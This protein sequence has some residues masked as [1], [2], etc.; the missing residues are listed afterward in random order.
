MK[1][2]A[3][4]PV[5]RFVIW[6]ARR[7]VAGHEPV[8]QAVSRRADLAAYTVQDSPTELV[9]VRLPDGRVVEG[10]RAAPRDRKSV[11]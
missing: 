8:S 9:T 1:E 3:G 4:K 5:F 7:L 10:E 2:S 6:L 11:V